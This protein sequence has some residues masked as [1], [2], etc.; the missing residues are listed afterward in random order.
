MARPA[1]FERATAGT[2]NQCSIQL[3][4]ERI[5][6]WTGIIQK[7]R[8]D[9]KG[10]EKKFSFFS[11]KMHRTEK[12]VGRFVADEGMVVGVFEQMVAKT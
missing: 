7:I 12:T 5:S 1:R 4:Y 8:R 9:F 3:S 6:L 10:F 2:A 11:Q